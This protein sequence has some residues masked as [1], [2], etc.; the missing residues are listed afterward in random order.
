MRATDASLAST[1]NAKLVEL[2]AN[3]QKSKRAERLKNLIRSDQNAI[4]YGA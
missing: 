3:A 2:Q 4:Q 1:L